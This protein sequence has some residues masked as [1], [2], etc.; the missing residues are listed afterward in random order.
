MT[1]PSIAGLPMDIL[2]SLT[3]TTDNIMH[4][5]LIVQNVHNIFLVYIVHRQ[6]V[7]FILTNSVE[8][9]LD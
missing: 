6:Y 4:K 2:T 8:V 9:V 1:R 5:E 7:L 3:T